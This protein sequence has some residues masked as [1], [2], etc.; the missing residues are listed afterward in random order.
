MGACRV[1]PPIQNVRTVVNERKRKRKRSSGN[2]LRTFKGGFIRL[3]ETLP[4]LPARQ[5]HSTYVNASIPSG[6]A[7]S[8]ASAPRDPA[9]HKPRIVLIWDPMHAMEAFAELKLHADLSGV[10]CATCTELQTRYKYPFSRQINLRKLSAT[11]RTS[12]IQCPWLTRHCSVLATD[13]VSRNR[14]S[15]NVGYEMLYAQYEARYS[16]NSM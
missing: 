8:G 13:G 10:C 11:L 16:S 4:P 1:K 5:L 7:I 3:F 15:I 12:L 6:E 9:A 2:S 14:P